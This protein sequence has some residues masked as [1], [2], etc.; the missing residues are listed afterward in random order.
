MSEKVINRTIKKEQM[1]IMALTF[2]TVLLLGSVIFLLTR[3]KTEEIRISDNWANYAADSFSAGNGS[4]EDPFIIS[5]ARELSLLCKQVNDGE[6]TSGKCYAISKTIS[7]SGRD[8]LPIG[9]KNSFKGELDGRGNTIHKVEV[10]PFK[11]VSNYGLFGI[12]EGTLKNLTLTK[13]VVNLSFEDAKTYWSPRKDLFV[14]GLVGLN[15]G[16]VENCNVRATVELNGA[17]GA[18]VG[19]VC[20]NNSGNISLVKTEGQISLKESSVEA[21]GGLVGRM[22]EGLVEKIQCRANLKSDSLSEVKLAGG[23]VGMASDKA[24]LAECVT[25]FVFSSEYDMLPQSLGGFIAGN[26]NADVTSCV[27]YS[28][29]ETGAEKTFL[30]F[31]ANDNVHGSTNAG[32]T[33]KNIIKVVG[34]DENVTI[35]TAKSRRKFFRTDLKFSGSEVWTFSKNKELPSLVMKMEEKD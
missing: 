22:D 15:K 28:Y 6:D 35:K 16:T 14:G 17:E 26:D 25:K 11:K 4:K 34:S 27:C 2:V 12:N 18:N 5:N 8:W 3:V 10:V 23:F 31:A 29:N 30:E 19:L 1:P 33:S 24:S 7:L 13:T 32:Y 20:G 21:A 9:Y